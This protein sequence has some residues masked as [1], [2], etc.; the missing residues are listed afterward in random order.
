MAEL[1]LACD[2]LIC[3][4]LL[5]VMGLCNRLETEMIQE[6]VLSSHALLDARTA[7]GLLSSIYQP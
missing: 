3:F 5:N 4:T 6:K 1:F 2:I 7:T